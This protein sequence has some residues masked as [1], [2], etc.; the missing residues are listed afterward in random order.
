M[1]LW[2]SFTAA[3]SRPNTGLAAISTLM[4]PASSRA[5]TARCT[6]P[7]ERLRIGAPSPWVL[8]P[9]SAIHSRARLRQTGNF[10]RLAQPPLASGG[11]SKSRSAMFSATLRS[12]TQALR[13]GSS[14]RLRTLRRRFSSR[15]AP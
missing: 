13:S 6:L 12:P 4:S 3:K 9:Y 14:G 11:W 2:I 10:S 1:R 7:P 8:T 5:S 15:R